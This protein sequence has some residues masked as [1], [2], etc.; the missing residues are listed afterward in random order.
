LRALRRSRDDPK[1]QADRPLDVSFLI[2]S[3]PEIG[4]KVPGLKPDMTRLG[5]AGHS[6]GAW[7]VMGLAGA[8]LKHGGKSLGN[9]G[10]SRVKA[11]VAMSPQGLDESMGYTDG[12]WDL[13]RGPMLCLSGTKDRGMVG[14]EEPSWRLQAFEHMPAGDKFDLVLEGANHLD[15]A[16]RQLLGRT[17]PK[18][19]RAI[20][21]ETLAFWDS[22]LRDG[23][24]MKEG[25][26][27]KL[28][29]TKF[30]V[31]MK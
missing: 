28:E 24:R 31:L 1:A 2:R 14:G 12:S 20:L 6:Y 29:G 17:D 30:S 9:F 5:A 4:Q 3:L 7:T 11:F 16:D 18:Y 26:F 27:P 8:V 22:Y 23:K 21:A 25:D 19:H 15:F 13:V 10:D